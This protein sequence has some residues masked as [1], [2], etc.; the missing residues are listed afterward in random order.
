MTILMTGES[1][2]T[3]QLQQRFLALIEPYRASLE[4][5]CRSITD[6]TWEAEDL[7]QD[8]WLKAYSMFK[9]YPDR[10][11]M[12]KTYLF[13]IASN[14]MI[15]RSRKSRLPVQ[16]LAEQDTA[17]G[18]QPDPIEIRSAMEYLVAYL[19]PRQRAILLLIDVFQFTASEV[20]EMIHTTEGAVKSGLHRARTKLREIGRDKCRV[21]ESLSGAPNSRNSVDEKV[22]Y[23][24]IEAFHQQNAQAMLMLHNDAA[25]LDLVPMVRG[26]RTTSPTD[27]ACTKSIHT[28]LAFSNERLI[29]AA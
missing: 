22:V 1:L 4:W 20:A 25:S 10:N 11:E 18:S 8:T 9:R 29:K 19:P 23:A 12:S 15:D 7:A 21:S 13:R 28:G 2:N 14:T 6:S 27:M 26:G 3:E 16:G 5:Y 24:Y 17:T